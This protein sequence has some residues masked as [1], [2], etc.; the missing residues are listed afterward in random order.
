MRNIIVIAAMLC[1]VLVMPGRSAGAVEWGAIELAG[2]KVAP[3]E[4]VKFSFVRDDTFEA[5]YLDTPIFAARGTAP[6]PTLCLSAGIHG[7]EINGVEVARRAFAETAVSGLAGTLI[8]LP[9][10]NADGCRA[11]SRYLS[12]RRDLNRF[13]PGRENGSVASLIANAV[14][15]RIIRQCDALID[16]HTAS[17]RRANLPQIRVDLAHAASRELA[18]HFGLGIIIGG[19]G[20]DGSLRREAVKAGVPAIIYEAGESMRFQPEEITAG[21]QGVTNAMV[22][23]GM[24][25]GKLRVVP[26]SNIYRHTTWVRVPRNGAGFFFPERDLGDR[27]SAGEELG[28]IVDPL[29]DERRSLSAPV[30]G[31]IIGMAVPQVVLSGYAL[32]H[33]GTHD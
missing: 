28:S 23:L 17:F 5:S 22:Y 16:L 25:K 26:T 33:V 4:K 18:R 11:G 31:Q 10:I 21:V 3:G 1:G 19:A 9:A 20:P 8:A 27:I 29:T 24:V 7:D 13:F 12:D 32:F 30:G 2:R 6:G 14:F 15:S